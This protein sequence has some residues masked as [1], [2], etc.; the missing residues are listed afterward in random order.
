MLTNYP[1]PIPILLSRYQ[2]H[3]D[4]YNG[5]IQIFGYSSGAGLSFRR[6]TKLIEALRCVQSAEVN[7]SETESAGEGERERETE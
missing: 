5:Y 7:C 4:R 6:Q 1:V 3:I 2:T